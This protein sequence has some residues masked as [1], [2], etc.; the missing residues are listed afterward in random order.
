MFVRF[1]SESSPLICDAGQKEDEINAFRTNITC[2]CQTQLY[3]KIR[4]SLYVCENPYM[5]AN[6]IFR[7]R[8]APSFV[9]TEDIQAYRSRM[10]ASGI[11]RASRLRDIIEGEVKPLKR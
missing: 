3:Q 9:E 5:H 6:P 11:V 10:H 1:T 4:A 8:T 7:V 2:V